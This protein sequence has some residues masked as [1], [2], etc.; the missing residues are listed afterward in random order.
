MA[1]KDPV[2][3]GMAFAIS[4]GGP[5][6]KSASEVLEFLQSK[7]A[8]EICTASTF[9]R[10]LDHYIPYP[11][12]PV[13]DAKYLSEAFVPKPPLELVREVS[14][15]RTPIMYGHCK[16][17]GMNDVGNRQ[18]IDTENEKCNDALSGHYYAATILRSPQL[19]YFLES[20]W[21]A[22]AP[23][24]LF[25]RNSDEVNSHDS[26]AARSIKE[27]YLKKG[28]K[29]DSD[30]DEATAKAFGDAFC[31]GGEKEPF[32]NRLCESPYSLQRLIACYYEEE[33]DFILPGRFSS[34]LVYFVK[35]IQATTAQAIYSYRFDYGGAGSC[36]YGSFVSSSPSKRMLKGA[37]AKLG[38]KV[39]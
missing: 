32:V 30:K 9:L 27:L 6:A 26:E 23:I 4:L 1:D 33:S 37:L 21:D 7:S 22:V 16:D 13:I 20:E 36:K 18:Q 8:E 31:V 15:N 17:E 3:L 19:S 25:N 39:F 29:Q 5:K 35:T 38:I 11:W 34:G 12:L 24:A 2:A 10:D 14:Y 28:L